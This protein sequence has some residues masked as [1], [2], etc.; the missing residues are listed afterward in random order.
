[1]YVASQAIT[2]YTLSKYPYLFRLLYTC[3]SEVGLSHVNSP[4]I[5]LGSAQKILTM[6][7]SD[8]S[9]RNS[10]AVCSIRTD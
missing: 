3:L 9:R 10:V 4:V 7:V 1:M 2:V 5:K 6:G 8:N